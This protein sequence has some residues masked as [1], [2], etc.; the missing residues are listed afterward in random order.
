MFS[1]ATMHHWPLR[2]REGLGIPELSY[3]FQFDPGVIDERELAWA[4]YVLTRGRTPAALR[5]HFTQVYA[6]K[7]WRVFGRKP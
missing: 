3:E 5:R 2:L 4:D 7:H 1:F 6:G